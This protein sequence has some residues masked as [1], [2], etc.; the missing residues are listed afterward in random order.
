M[1]KNEWKISPYER[2]CVGARSGLC[3]FH[4]GSSREELHDLSLELH[5]CFAQARLVLFR[6]DTPRVLCIVISFS[7]CPTQCASTE[8]TGRTEGDIN[9][10]TK[11]VSFSPAASRNP[12]K[13]NKP[14]VFILGS[15]KSKKKKNT[16]CAISYDNLRPVAP[17]L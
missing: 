7:F 6:T 5:F 11:R 4:R 15:E 12:N 17:C 3:P 14:E 2:T 16:S 9:I 8:P 1:E 13:I 10:A